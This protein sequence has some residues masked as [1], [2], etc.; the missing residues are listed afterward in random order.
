MARIWDFKGAMLPEHR[1]VIHAT[2]GAFYLSKIC[3]FCTFSVKKSNSRLS[4]PPYWITTSIFWPKM[5]QTDQV[6]AQARHVFTWVFPTNTFIDVFI[7]NLFESSIHPFDN[8]NKNTS[9]TNTTSIFISESLCLSYSP[10]HFPWM[11]RVFF[12]ISVSLFSIFF[13]FS[14]VGILCFFFCSTCVSTRWSGLGLRREREMEG[15]AQADM[16]R[17][18]IKWKYRWKFTNKRIQMF[19]CRVELMWT[20]HT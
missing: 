12:F 4:G 7:H 15:E 8:V 17:E 14:Y 5:S 18:K 11:F 20:S 10:S 13:T 19:T 2:F 6:L 1:S 16:Y 9:E 3:H